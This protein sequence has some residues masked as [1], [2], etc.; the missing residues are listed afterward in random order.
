MT[1]S[2]HHAQGML[3]GI[4]AERRMRGLTGPHPLDRVDL[5]RPE[6]RRLVGAIYAHMARDALRRR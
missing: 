6:D 3:E 2:R 1:P 5:D 4:R